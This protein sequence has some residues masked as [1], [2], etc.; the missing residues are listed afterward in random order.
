[1]A[2]LGYVSRTDLP[3]E[4]QPIYDHIEATRDKVLNVF[5]AMLKSPGAAEAVAAVGEY[6]RYKSRLDPVVREI[7]TLMT[8]REH[9][10]EYEWAQHLPLA[11]QAGVSEQAIEAIR[12]GRAPMGIPAKEGVFAQAAKELIR[13]GTLGDRTFQAIE[14]LLGPAQTID[15]IVLVGYYTM[16]SGVIRALGV[17]LE[18]GVESDL[19]DRT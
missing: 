11:R 8:A 10:N 16:L 15:L 12:S 13:D 9:D 7:A 6:I 2:R 19:A 3:P 17:E 18:E 4:E 14:H 1:M 5:R